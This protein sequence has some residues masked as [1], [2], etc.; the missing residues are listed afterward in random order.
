MALTTVVSN[1]SLRSSVTLRY[2]GLEKHNIKVISP[3]VFLFCKGRNYR[4]QKRE[5]RNV[6]K[7]IGNHW[8]NLDAFASKSKRFVH[9]N[10]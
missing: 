10:K 2:I 5:R 4:F 6:S 3:A 1:K 8:Y 9:L 7:K